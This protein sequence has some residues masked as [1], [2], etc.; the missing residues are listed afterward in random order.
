MAYNTGYNNVLVLEDDFGFIDDARKVVKDIDTFFQM[1]MHQNTP[2][3][4]PSGGK[5]NSSYIK[6]YYSQLK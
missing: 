3:L 2:K 5:C 6:Y 1:K 4:L